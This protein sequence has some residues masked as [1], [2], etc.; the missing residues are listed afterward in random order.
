MASH[1]LAIALKRVYEPPAPTDGKRVLVE[2]LWPRG[3]SKAQ[4]Q[5]DLWFKEI[6]PSSELRTWYGHDPAKYAEF[7]RRYE[8]ELAAEPAQEALERLREL[9]HQKQVT[10]V[11]AAQDLEHSTAPIIRDLLT[12]SFE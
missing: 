1:A 8:A 5:V 6:A 11:V 7:R 10:L 12:R 2:R 9:A 4:A 3:L